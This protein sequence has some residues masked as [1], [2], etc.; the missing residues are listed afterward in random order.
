MLIHGIN[1][2]LHLSFSHADAK[3]GK[4][5][6]KY[7]ILCMKREKERSLMIFGLIGRLPRSKESD[8]EGA[9]RR[10]GFATFFAMH[11]NI[12]P[13]NLEVHNG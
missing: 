10:R 8:T 3:Q 12:F 11:L 5:K 4:K 1:L 7:N 6:K 9:L 2:G 13:L